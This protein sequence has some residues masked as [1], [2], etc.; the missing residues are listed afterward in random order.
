MLDTVLWWICAAAVAVLWVLHTGSLDLFGDLSG[1][2]LQLNMMA[3]AALSLMAYLLTSQLI[4]HF[5]PLFEK[6]G[7]YGIDLSKA[8]TYTG[9][10]EDKVKVPEA[11]G[12]IAAAMYLI[13]MFL[14]IPF[15]FTP[16]LLEREGNTFPHHE[17]VEFICGLLAICCMVFLGFADDVLNLKWRHKFI[18]PT[19][20]SLP[21]LVVYYV[22]GGATTI[23]VPTFLRGYLG[24][25]VNLGALYHI[26]MLMLSVFCT[27]AINIHAGI[28]GIEA[29]QSFVIGLSI[30][31]HNVLQIQIGAMDHQNH[32][33]SLFLL[34]PFVAVTWAILRANWFPAQCFVGDTYCYFA[35]MTFAV[36]GI[37]GHFGKTMIL[38][39]IPQAFNFVFSLP[40]L[41]KLVP[42]PR[43]RMPKFDPNTG[44]LVNSVATFK[45]GDI[46]AVGHL[47]VNILR[48]LKM[49]SYRKYEDDQGQVQIEVSNFTV[50]NLIMRVT[51]PINERDLAV[52]ALGV[53]VTFSL[54]AFYIRY[55]VALHFYEGHNVRVASDGTLVA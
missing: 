3:N 27:N 53:Q 51:G 5:S 48:S 29:G 24:L 13:S 39:F 34:M 28:N 50:L 23:I 4:P 47:I 2:R 21:L 32:E 17:L 11:L 43:H 45:P 9:K 14:F 55:E 7:L 22:N 40:Q 25:S 36:A 33:L 12:T 44:M 19:A 26:Y 35:G 42:C 16:F 49:I 10:D 1:S 20:A 46:S 15:Y 31:A 38:F 18:I 54:V 8:T 37:L 52:Y 30:M 41:L 6:A